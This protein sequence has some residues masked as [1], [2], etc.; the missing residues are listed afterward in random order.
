MIRSEKKYILSLMKDER[1]GTFN[2]FVKGCL[3]VL[4]W[5][6]TVVIRV[7]DF[8]WR[9]RI[10]H[11]HKVNAPVVSVGN[12]T[13][14]GT[15]K[16]PFTVFLAD[17]FVDKGK[18]PA[19]LTRG[20][21]KDEAIMLK[22]EL[23]EVPVFIG[24]D[25]VKNA[26]LAV[27][28][29]RDVLILDDAFQHRRIARDLNIVLLDSTDFLGN[30]KLFPRGVLR[31]PVFSLQR[32]DVLVLT[33]TDRIDSSRGEKIAS[34]L[35]K[36]APGKPVIFTRHKPA[37]LKD[38]GGTIHPLEMLDGKEVSLFSGIVD[39]D[40]FASLVEGLGAE[41]TGRCDFTDHHKYSQNDIDNILKDDSEIM[42][43]TAKD[44][45]KVRSLDISAI[46]GKLFVLHIDMDITKGKEI[47]S[48]RL[49]SIMDN[50]RL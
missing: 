38:A 15:G 34:Q 26:L 28:S 29:E 16:T 25:R 46:E 7:I 2:T 4:S 18:S 43:T 47:L 33:K 14:G 5:I 12:I 23:A 9:R 24:Q 41:V 45:V 3:L 32:A 10:R 42:V 35:E 31:E 6:Y 1:D 30:G 13:L 37:F 21:G 11:E 50:N 20:Y 8:M 48:A 22:D 36:I 49:D 27:S 17:Y 44:Y 19:V 39:A 40:Y